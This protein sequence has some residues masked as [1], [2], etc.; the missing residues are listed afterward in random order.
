MRPH[1]MLPSM[2]ALATICCAAP[3]F[4]QSPLFGPEQFAFAGK[5]NCDGHF[6]ENGKTH[7]HRVLYEGKIVSDGQW[8][9]LSQKDIEPAGYAADFLMGYDRVN[10]ELIAFVGDNKGYAVLTGPVWQGSALTLTMT[11]QASYPGFSKEKPLPLSRVTYRVES[12]DVWTATWEVQ[13]GKNWNEDDLLTCKR[14]TAS[15]ANG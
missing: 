11:G 14:M 6:F 15:P 1:P 13:A 4:A 10:N 5:W 8:I 3:V 12:A 7:V 2:L 9:D